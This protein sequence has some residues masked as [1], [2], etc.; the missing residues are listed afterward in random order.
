MDQAKEFLKRFEGKFVN[1]ENM[2]EEDG[3]RYGSY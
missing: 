3:L 2:T 1:E